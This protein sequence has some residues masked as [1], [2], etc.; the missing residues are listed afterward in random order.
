MD[1]ITADQA[2]KNSDDA[3]KSAQ[4]IFEQISATISA[5]SKAGKTEIVQIFTDKIC[6]ENEANSVKSRLEG[7]GFSVRISKRPSDKVFTVNW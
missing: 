3:D 2:R 1:E 6:S 7:N 5:N 4:A